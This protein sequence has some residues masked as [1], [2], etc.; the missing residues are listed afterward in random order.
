[1][2]IYDTKVNLDFHRWATTNVSLPVEVVRAV[3]QP[4]VN[5]PIIRPVLTTGERVLP[6]PRSVLRYLDSVEKEPHVVHFWA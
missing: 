1:M 4:V 5:P 6:P 3:S 2:R